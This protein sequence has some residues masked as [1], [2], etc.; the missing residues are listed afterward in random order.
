M[1]DLQARLSKDIAEIS[2][3][4]IVPHV[5][6]DAVIIVKPELDLSEVAAA[7]A[8]DNTPSVRGW[9]ADNSITKP[10]VEQLS[11]WN[12]NPQKQFTALIV[13]PFVVVK[14]VSTN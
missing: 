3:T 10:T 8:E 7:I 11:R 4:D 5:K 14:E 6:R 13:Q 1:P 9:I 2:W 12:D